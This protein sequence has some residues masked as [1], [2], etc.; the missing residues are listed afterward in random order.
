MKTPRGSL[1]HSTF[2]DFLG[3]SYFC[4]IYLSH[5]TTRK[6]I[7]CCR[8]RYSPKSNGPPKHQIVAS[9]IHLV[10][11]ARHE[12]HAH[13]VDYLMLTVKKCRLP[14]YE[15]KSPS[16]YRGQLYCNSDRPTNPP[17]YLRDA[18]VVNNQTARNPI[19]TTHRKLPH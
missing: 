6:P 12:I 10:L 9:Y 5:T 4:R 8:R 1:T 14:L 17:L 16:M 19:R 15:A 18:L 3:W 11:V 7:P 13:L 2:V